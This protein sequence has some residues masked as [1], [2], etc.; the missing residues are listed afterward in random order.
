MLLITWTKKRIFGKFCGQMKQKLSYLAVM[1]RDMCEREK[2]RPLTP[3]YLQSG[4]VVVLCSEPVLLL[5]ELV[6]LQKKNGIMETKENL[7]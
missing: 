3:P 7:K 6:I 1:T 4:M 2:V 5:V